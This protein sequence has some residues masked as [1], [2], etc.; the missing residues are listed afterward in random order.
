MTTIALTT[1]FELLWAELGGPEL[2]SEF[3]FHPA[4]RWRFDYCHETAKAAIEIDGGTFVRGRHSRGVGYRNDCIKINVAQLMG[5]RVFRLT[6]DMV[7]A[8]HVQ[9]IIDF[10][11]REAEASR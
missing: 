7:N 6:T 4:R 11:R 2:T 3:R 1:A 9:P 8:E 5:Y 10:V